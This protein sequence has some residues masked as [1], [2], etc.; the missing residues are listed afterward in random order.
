MNLTAF[1]CY[2]QPLWACE[3]MDWVTQE[4]EAATVY[5]LVTHCHQQDEIDLAAAACKESQQRAE[6]PAADPQI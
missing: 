2:E 5:V 6:T 3:Q 1:Y 4:R